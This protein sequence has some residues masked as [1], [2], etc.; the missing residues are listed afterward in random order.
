MP[1]SISDGVK[2]RLRDASSRA[3]RV[4]SVILV[5][6][7]TSV[8]PTSQPY[9]LYGSSGSAS[10]AYFSRSARKVFIAASSA[11]VGSSAALK[12][13]ADRMPWAYW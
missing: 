13:D 6:A 11:Q 1:G 2:S 7:W 5:S 4:G 3:A 12:Y 9:T 10:G 8:S